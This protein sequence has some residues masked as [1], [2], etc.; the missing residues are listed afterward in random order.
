MT[1]GEH[2]GVRRREGSSCRMRLAAGLRGG[3]LRRRA[4]GDEDERD[5]RRQHDQRDPA[6][7]PA[8]EAARAASRRASS[9]RSPGCAG[10]RSATSP[11]SPRQREED[12][13]EVA[14]GLDAGGV[15]ASLGQ[16]AV[17]LGRAALVDAPTSSVP[18]S[19]S[20]MRTASGAAR[21]PAGPAAARLASA[22]AHAHPDDAARRQQLGE[23]P[24][25]T[26]RPRSMMPTT[27]AS[28][29]TSGRM[30]LETR[31]VLPWPV[32]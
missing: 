2:E 14:A 19:P 25:R 13:L 24:S 28:C 8:D 16:R 9:G 15:D 20:S 30:W 32:R 1:N 3:L 6:R 4:E 21:R 29:W 23:R 27:S 22:A 18:G 11:P 10:G 12:R 5:Q 17:D 7:R 31:T 26:S